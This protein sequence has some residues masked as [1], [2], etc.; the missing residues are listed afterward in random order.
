[1]ISYDQSYFSIFIVFW[2]TW[3]KCKKIFLTVFFATFTSLCELLWTKWETS[4]ISGSID[5]VQIILQK[6]KD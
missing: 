3:R 4:Q 6:I 1:M 2:R 5:F